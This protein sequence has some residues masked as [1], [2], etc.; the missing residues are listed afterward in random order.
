MA[1]SL[2]KTKKTRAIAAAAKAA[3]KKSAKKA[4]AKKAAAP[5]KKPTA[6]GSA[7]FLPKYDQPLASYSAYAQHR[8]L[9]E[10]FGTDEA[11]QAKVLKHGT[12]VL[13]LPESQVKTYIR[14]KLLA[15]KRDAEKELGLHPSKPQMEKAARGEY[16]PHFKHGSKDAA[17]SALLAI[18]RRNGMTDACFHILNEGGKFAVVP[19]HVRPAGKPPQFEKGDIVMDTTI[20]DS[21]AKVLEAGPEASHIEYLTERKYAPKDPTVS[22]YYLHKIATAKTA[23]AANEMARDLAKDVAKVAKNAAAL[24]K[25]LPAKAAQAA[26]PAAKKSAVKK[27]PAKKKAAK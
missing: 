3:V 17:R 25:K 10:K 22:N 15:I 14:E 2:Q 13:G 9:L 16:E 4:T 19:A 27:A 6:S 7:A 24:V 11:G 23:K 26:K 21:R 20:A 18:V 5:A 8:I 12:E 1:K